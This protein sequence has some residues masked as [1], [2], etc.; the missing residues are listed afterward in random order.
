[1]I[2]HLTPQGAEALE[3]NGNLHRLRTAYGDRLSVVTLRHRSGIGDMV[4]AINYGCRQARLP[5]PEW[6]LEYDCRPNAPKK[7]R[8]SERFLLCHE[9]TAPDG[10][11]IKCWPDAACQLTFQQGPLTSRLVMLLEYDRS[12]EDHPDLVD[13]LPAYTA[14]FQTQ[15]YL[16]HWPKASRAYLFFVLQN[17]ERL[18]NVAE[19]LHASPLADRIRLAV[20]KELIA[21]TPITAPVWYTTSLERRAL[22][23]S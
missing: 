21:S 9:F 5:V 15:A 8:F 1:V 17:I 7:A 14:M 6:L 2:Y 4:L 18:R 13:K 22:L 19:L 16:Q 3:L 23:G 10:V 20:A 12:T 11:R